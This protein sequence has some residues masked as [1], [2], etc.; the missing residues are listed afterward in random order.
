MA[1]ETPGNPACAPNNRSS[2]GAWLAFGLGVAA[3]LASLPWTWFGTD[4]PIRDE[5]THMPLVRQWLE[6][7]ESISIARFPEPKGAAFFAAGKAWGGIFGTSCPALRSMVVLSAVG[8][9]AAWAWL[10]GLWG[11]PRRFAAGIALLAVP[12]FFLCTQ[13][14]L[15]EMPALLLAFLGLAMAQKIRGG[16]GIGWAIGV[17]LSLGAMLWVRQIFV[18]VPLALLVLSPWAGR[19]RLKLAIAV[20]ASLLPLAAMY[21]L[22][23]AMV[24]PGAIQRFHGTGGFYPSTFLFCLA[25]LGALGWPML[26]AALPRRRE[27]LFILA[28]AALAMGIYLALPSD[29]YAEMSA[30]SK[31]MGLVQTTLLSL[32]GPAWAPRLVLLV[33]ICAGGAVF[34]RL[35]YLLVGTG[36]D[37]WVRQACAIALMGTAIWLF[38]APVFF[39]RYLLLP[40]VMIFAIVS[41]RAV[42][43]LAM[44]CIVLFL[45]IAAGHAA[46]VT[47]HPKQPFRPLPI[48][49]MF[50]EGSYDAAARPPPEAHRWT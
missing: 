44:G 2:R 8:A 43:P 11:L 17:A 38:A 49:D 23:G 36:Q 18:V 45:L 4:N 21:M 13:M 19:H 29:F 35:A 31:R 48:K 27:R 41:Q 30:S 40:L 1:I 7:P 22:W 14:F 47:R 6:R 25:V 20:G 46:Y 12:Y 50:H 26:L 33:A 32:P 37:A 5:I 3:I 42:R 15:T 16:G 9:L 10:T 34:G 24:P 28:G 39:D